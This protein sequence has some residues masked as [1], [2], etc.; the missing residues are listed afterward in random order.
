[1]KVPGRSKSMF[2]GNCEPHSTEIFVLLI[3][4]FVRIWVELQELFTDEFCDEK[5]RVSMR[6]AP[7]HSLPHQDASEVRCAMVIVL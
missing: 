2:H 3:N 6:N 5:T 4:S 1:M 7:P